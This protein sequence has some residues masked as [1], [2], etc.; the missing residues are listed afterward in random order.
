MIE[1][2]HVERIAAPAAAV[3]DLVRWENLER[4]GSGLFKSVHYQERR[5]VV[6][7]RRRIELAEGGVIEERLEGVDEEGRWLAYRMLD[8][9]PVPI[10]DYS[11]EVRVSAAGPETTFIRFSCRCTPVGLSEADWRVLYGQMQSANVAAIRAALVT[12]G[13]QST[14]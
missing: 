5:P 3:W 12:Q 4:L 7:A 2:E 10:A 14:L 6:G 11:G 13:S 9:G 8:T 1:L